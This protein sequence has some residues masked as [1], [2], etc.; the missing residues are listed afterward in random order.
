MA[1]EKLMKIGE[2][3]FI[4]ASNCNFRLPETNCQHR[5]SCKNA[6]MTIGDYKCPLGV[7]RD[8]SKIYI[9]E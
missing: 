3:T 8:M 6:Y 5:E 1:K 7:I 2:L 9:Q 4:I